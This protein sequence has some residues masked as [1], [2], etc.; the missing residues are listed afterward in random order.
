MGTTVR[1]GNI[2]NST[3]VAAGSHISQNVTVNNGTAINAM[4]QIDAIGKRLDD[5]FG[6]VQSRLED[7]SQRQMAEAQVKIIQTEMGK[8]EGPDDTNVA[9]AIGEI[10]DMDQQIAG[11]ILEI[12]GDPAFVEI[13]G[14]NTAYELKKLRRKYDIINLSSW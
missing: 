12:F 1:V 6:L 5:L 4:S 8:I 13:T 14:D 11:R 9:M 7:N 3:G 2:S 10:S